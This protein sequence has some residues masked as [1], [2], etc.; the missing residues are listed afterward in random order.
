MLDGQSNVCVMK[1]YIDDDFDSNNSSM[2]S[3]NDNN[4]NAGWP[5]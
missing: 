4:N 2:N 3:D 1:P 5:K